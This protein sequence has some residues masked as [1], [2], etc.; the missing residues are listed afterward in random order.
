MR[1]APVVAL[2]FAAALAIP[3]PAQNV[4]LPAQLQF[5]MDLE[6]LSGG[7]GET[8]WSVAWAVPEFAA[9]GRALAGRGYETLV[10]LRRCASIR[11]LTR[12]QL[13]WGEI[14]AA[15]VRTVCYGMDGE[16]AGLCTVLE[17]RPDDAGRA[18]ALF[19]AEAA[20]LER[21][22][23]RLLR[24][25]EADGWRRF[26]VEG[27]PG[28]WLAQR[29]A[30][31]AEGSGDMA[32]PSLEPAARGGGGSF[33]MN[34][35]PVAVWANGDKDRAILAASGFADSVRANCE[36]AVDGAGF[37][38]SFVLRGPLKVSPQPEGTVAGAPMP[39]LAEPWLC[40]RAAFEPGWLVEVLRT[41][42]AHYLPAVDAS[43]LAP[44][45]ER[46]D[47]RIGL[48]IG[49][50]AIGRFVPR[51]GLVLGVKDGPALAREFTERARAAAGSGWTVEDGPTGPFVSW[52]KD[53]LPP[54]LRP[55]FAVA[56]GA[57][58][59]AETPAT[60]RS[61]QTSQAS[62]DDPFQ[63]T[64]AMGG[65]MP[66]GA[67]VLGDCWFDCAAIYRGAA[68]AWGTQLF[69]AALLPNL[70][71]PLHRVASIV[72]VDD[73]PDPD[74][75]APALGHGRAVLYVGADELGMRVEAP[76]L[77]P[78]LTAAWATGTA[79][80]PRVVA[81]ALEQRMRSAKVEATMARAQRLGEALVR[82]KK[83]NG[84][85]LPGEIGDLVPLLPPGDDE[86]LLALHDPASLP[87][88]VPGPDGKLGEMQSSFQRPRADLVVA[89][90]ARGLEPVRL[91]RVPDRRELPVFAFCGGG[92]LGH[93]L[94]VRSNGDVVW[95]PSE[96]LLK[97]I[98]G[99]PK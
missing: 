98:L 4:T 35:M 74:D 41:Y 11:D 92:Y 62:C 99:E 27:Q 97:A 79:L 21:A 63:G 20:R 8:G 78:V 32:V 88:S 64:T 15:Q 18:A 77:G 39:S 45:L 71:S 59:F 84:D 87:L 82:Y 61:L 30:C 80:V 3:A 7:R 58:L 6:A 37:R 48:S 25:T 75:V 70:D 26:V 89:P 96:R 68:A 51:F 47:G 56:D 38:E 81:I 91:P 31:L 60:L 73:L 85:R 34:S 67:R 46:L 42:L 10:A 12:V 55:S 22:G 93:H 94:V 5:R 65:G 76:V 69:A 28:L 83:Q 29:G 2:A 13:P 1:Q 17:L 86:P 54:T 14:D 44:L 49:A 43:A 23:A 53:S 33:T 66:A 50:P 72:E 40:A 16:R 57:V 36:I 52:G 9:M 95:I 24:T 90:V 19:D